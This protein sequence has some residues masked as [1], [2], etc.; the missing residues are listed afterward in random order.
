MHRFVK[1]TLQVEVIFSLRLAVERAKTLALIGGGG[2]VRNEEGGKE[3]R[4]QGSGGE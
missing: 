3:A 2:E 4:K 1:R